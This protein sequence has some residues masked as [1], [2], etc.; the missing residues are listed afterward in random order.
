MISENKTLDRVYTAK[1]HEELMGAYKEWADAYDQDLDAFGYQAHVETAEALD[2]I[3]DDKEAVIL[4]AGSGTGLVGEELKKRGFR[5]LD[6]LDYSRDMLEQARRKNIYRTLHHADL[7][8]PL[9]LDDNAYDAVTCAG[10]FT[11]GH[12]SPDAFDELIRTT[13][14]GGFIC[15]TV[16][17]GAYDACG[18]GQR[19]TE[20]ERQNAWELLALQD[21]DYLK[22]EGVSCKLCTYKVKPDFHPAMG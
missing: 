11:F 21:A 12:V 18:Y 22:N 20:L 14:P 2:Q 10:T 13:R 4:D 9:D 17:E 15:F 6:A 1:T 3:L 5:H 8:K 16:R 7:S 19:M